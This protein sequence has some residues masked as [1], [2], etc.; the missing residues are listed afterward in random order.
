M[1]P[2]YMMKSVR[3]YRMQAL[4]NWLA[5]EIVTPK[6]ESSAVARMRPFDWGFQKNP[7]INKLNKDKNL[8]FLDSAYSNVKIDTGI[9]GVGKMKLKDLWAMRQD[10][11]NKD[12]FPAI[13]EALRAVVLRVPMDSVSGAHALRFGGFTGVQGHGVLMHGR[14]VELLGGAD[15]DADTAFVFFGGRKAD[16]SG[17]GMK[18]CRINM[19]KAGKDEFT[20]GKTMLNPK[21]L[22]K[23]D[24]KDL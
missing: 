9:G 2:I 22:F 12:Y 19:F 6:V 20:I 1:L 14:K 23:N 7:I 8:F 13:D 10:K 11:A 4:R 5:S 24:I 21:E 3:D 16:G 18:K 17:E 15:H